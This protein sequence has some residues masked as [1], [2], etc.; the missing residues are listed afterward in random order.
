MNIDISQLALTI[1]PISTEETYHLIYAI[2]DTLPLLLEGRKLSKD[3]LNKAY[4][5]RKFR[6]I[7]EDKKPLNTY[8]TKETKVKLEKLR[9]ITIIRPYMIL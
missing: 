2:Y 1:F 3:K 9:G 4:S 7:N 8:L 6:K 5:Q